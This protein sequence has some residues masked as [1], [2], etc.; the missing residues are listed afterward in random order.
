MIYKQIIFIS[1]AD[2]NGETNGGFSPDDKEAI[3]L[4]ENGLSNG[5]NTA[6]EMQDESDSCKRKKKPV[7]QLSK[8]NIAIVHFKYLVGILTIEAFS[9]YANSNVASFLIL[10]LF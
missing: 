6:V 10:Y 3:E 2:S 5:V 4:K 1:I 7:N 8:F 9:Q